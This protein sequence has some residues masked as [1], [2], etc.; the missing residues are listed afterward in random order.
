MGLLSE[1]LAAL[2]TGERFLASMSSHMHVHRV[3]VLEAFAADVA[4]VHDFQVL[5]GRLAHLSVAYGLAARPL[6]LVAGGHHVE[7]GGSRR[8]RAFVQSIVDLNGRR[9]PLQGPGQSWSLEKDLVASDE[10]TAG[11]AAEADVAVA[12]AVIIVVHHHH[13]DSL[14]GGGP[15]AGRGQRVLQEGVVV[16]VGVGVEVGSAVGGAFPRRSVPLRRLWGVAVI[17]LEGQLQVNHLLAC[18]KV[19]QV[20]HRRRAQG[21]G[22]QAVVA[23]TDAAV[24][25]VV[26]VVDLGAADVIAEEEETVLAGRVVGVVSHQD[27]LAV[28]QGDLV[29]DVLWLKE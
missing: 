5:L 14:L 3:S 29:D 25:V 4:V 2:S 24:F 11:V 26:A 27:L 13:T 20:L 7:C 8:D 19:Q 18:G 21:I 28:D 15:E 9:H 10:V 16:I 22:R 12:L 17:G 6:V 1:S 23:G